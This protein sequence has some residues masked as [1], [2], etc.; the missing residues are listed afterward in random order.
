[1]A[2]NQLPAVTTPTALQPTRDVKAAQRAFFQAAL[3]QAQAAT[4]VQTAAPR[5]QATRADPTDG[6]KLL[7]PGSLLDIRI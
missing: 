3:G 6:R 5:P 4:P 2:V 1:M 7:P